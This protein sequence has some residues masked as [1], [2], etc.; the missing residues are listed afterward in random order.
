[1]TFD[2]RISNSLAFCALNKVESAQKNDQKIEILLKNGKL[3]I[4]VH[5]C[6]FSL[7]EIKVM[8]FYNRKTIT[9]VFREDK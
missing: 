8:K 7:I 5:V 2:F 3:V 9:T 4:M 6:L 1:M